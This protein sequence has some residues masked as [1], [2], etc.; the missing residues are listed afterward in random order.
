MWVLGPSYFHSVKQHE[1]R[2]YHV[3]GAQ[4]EL[5]ESSLAQGC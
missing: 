2:T 5:K 1:V 3:L 4:N